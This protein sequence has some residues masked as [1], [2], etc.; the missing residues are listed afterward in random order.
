MSEREEAAAILAKDLWAF[1]QYVLPDYSFG[2][3]HREVLQG[4]GA[5]DRL[6]NNPNV[7]YLLPRDHLKSVMVA[8][9]SA[10]RVAGDPAY[11]MLYVTA[12]EDLG[13]LQMSFLQ[14]I[15]TSDQFR[16]LWP[17]HFVKDVGRRDKWT[18]LA[19][20]TDHPRRTELNIRDETIAVKT[21]RSDKCLAKG[22]FIRMYD[23][24]TK[25][26]EN[27]LEGDQLMGLDGTPRTVSGLQNG[28]E[29]LYDISCVSLPTYRCNQSHIL[30]LEN[31]EQE[32]RDISVEDYLSLGIV[33][34]GQWYASLRP[35]LTK[36]TPSLIHPRTL[37]MWLGDGHGKG[38]EIYGIDRKIFEWLD[39]NEDGYLFGEKTCMAYRCEDL[40]RKLRVLD[41]LNNKHIPES[42]LRSSYSDRMELLAGLIDTDGHCVDKTSFDITQK[43]KTLALDIQKL[44]HSL[45]MR[46]YLRSI[47]KKSQYMTEGEYW[48]LAIMPS[49]GQTVPVLIV[50]KQAKCPKYRGR[51]IQ[52]TLGD[53]GEFYGFSLDGDGRFLLANG[54][55]THNTGR[56]P[57]EIIYDD[58]VVPNNA[59][60]EMGRAEVRMGA[61]EAVSLAKKQCTN[62]CC[63]DRIH[64]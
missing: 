56:H 17:D 58:L 34:R 32:L 1:A 60:T 3:V 23:G 54:I 22:T 31:K 5:S 38:N 39:Q 6:E 52:V 59:Y 55:V 28:S 35:S 62:D 12:N 44:A 7:L 30:T 45:G 21:I 42:Y 9:Y 4:M 37:G 64:P 8:V 48:R 16:Y 29:R 2:D 11:T 18:S 57:D 33:E 25:A 53:I 63:R 27:V 20:N 50:R 13:R 61:S 41:L 19:I 43:N 15:F 36:Q 10:W 46:T 24:S 40:T 26:V 47:V 51:K 49:L 14:N